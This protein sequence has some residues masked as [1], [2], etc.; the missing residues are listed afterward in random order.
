MKTPLIFKK[1]NQNSI[2]LQQ[3]YLPLSDVDWHHAVSTQVNDRLV[4]CVGDLFEKFNVEIHE[5]G[6]MARVRPMASDTALDHLLEFEE[7]NLA[8]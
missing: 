8:M 5:H 2:L 7:T 3:S 6:H 1:N 4:L